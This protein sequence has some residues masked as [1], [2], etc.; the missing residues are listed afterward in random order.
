VGVFNLV[1][2]AVVGVQFQKAI[3]WLNNKHFGFLQLFNIP[4]TIA[5]VIGVLL[6]DIFM[7]WWHTIN[8][9]WRFLWY[10]HK[11]HHVIRN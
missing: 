6:I 9:E 5:I 1:L 4:S 10:F 8:H 3:E 11:F 2:I 7:Y